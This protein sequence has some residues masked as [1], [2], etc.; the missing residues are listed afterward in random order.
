MSLSWFF[1]RKPSLD[2]QLQVRNREPFVVNF[3]R[4]AQ[5]KNSAIP[6][7]QR[8]L[9]EYTSHHAEAA[10]GVPEGRR[11]GG[12]GQG[13]GGDAQRTS[14][15]H[16]WLKRYGILAEKDEFIPLDKVL[17]IVSGGSVINRGLPRLV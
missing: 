11:P 14:K 2:N 3:A 16:Y 6:D 15:S 17:K 13:A 5:Y 1:P 4:T 8:R 12:S 7:I 10:E 9:N